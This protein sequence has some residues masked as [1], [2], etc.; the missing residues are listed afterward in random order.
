[1]SASEVSPSRRFATYARSSEPTSICGKHAGRGYRRFSLPSRLRRTLL[2]DYEPFP[3]VD[4]KDADGNVRPVTGLPVDRDR[5]GGTTVALRPPEPV[6]DGRKA[7]AFRPVDGREK[8]RRRVVGERAPDAGLPAELRAVLAHVRPRGRHL[9]GAGDAAED[10]PLRLGERR[11][12]DEAV[13][14]VC[15][16]HQASRAASGRGERLGDLDSC[17]KVR[18]DVDEIRPRLERVRNPV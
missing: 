7:V 6:L 10:A 5:T 12:G 15:E 8:D 16:P 9:G 18:A 14:D 1:M 11:L 2:C 13:V 17:R 4:P 3:V